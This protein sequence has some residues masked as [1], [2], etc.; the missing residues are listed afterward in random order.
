KVVGVVAIAPAAN[1]KTILEQ[2]PDLDKRLGPYVAMSYSRFYRDVS[3]ER[4]IRPE[5]LAA[6]H[7]MVSLCGFLPPE[8]PRR[9]AVLTASFEGPALA[10]GA[11][12]A[13][14]TRI[15]ENTADRA[16]AAPVVI[17]QGAADDIV[18]AAATSAFVEQRCA[19]GQALEYWTFEAEGHGG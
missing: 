5:A 4:A 18:P 3:F 12:T 10:T 17:A 11:E 9:I 13:L 1:M 15:S 2:N 14:A 16:I 19:A 7:E 8:G 6:A